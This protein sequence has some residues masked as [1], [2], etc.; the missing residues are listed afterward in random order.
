[1][2]SPRLQSIAA[3]TLIEVLVSI[4]ILSLVVAAIYSSWTAILR[5]SKVGLDAAASAQRSRI[6][7]HT[8]ED[9]LST[10]ELFVRNSDYYGFVAENGNEPV[11]SFVARLPKSFPRSGRFGDLDV[12]R[13]TYTIEAGPDGGN[14]LVLRQQPIIMEMEKNEKET[15]LVLARNVKK[16][17]VGFWDERLKDWVDE[18]L[19]T[20]QLPKLV[21]INLSLEHRDNHS[22]Q[23]VQE[24][25]RV[26]ALTSAGVPPM[27]QTAGQMPGMPV[28]PPGTPGGLP[29]IPGAPITPGGPGVVP[30]P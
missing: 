6:A 10:A 25:T 27:F 17:E 20:N 29:T 3:F 9:S 7:L 11:L 23:T 24:I 8:I 1:M 26:I 13:L 18:W 28:V 30:R 22:G 5:S 21:K 14:A 4:A 2:K 19:L 12:R 15:P 16:F